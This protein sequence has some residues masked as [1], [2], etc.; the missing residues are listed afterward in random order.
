MDVSNIRT[1]L[2]EEVTLRD[3]SITIEYF[4]NYK[5]KAQVSS[6]RRGSMKTMLPEH[7]S[8]LMGVP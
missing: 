5:L 1:M 2:P 4:E 8:W 6:M 7:Y 3:M